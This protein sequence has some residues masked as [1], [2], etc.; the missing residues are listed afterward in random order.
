MRE[1]RDRD[2]RNSR[3]RDFRDRDFRDREP[4]DRDRD[5][6][7]VGERI[8]VEGMQRVRPGIVV[9]AQLKGPD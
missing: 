4:F 5:G 6:L 9:N 1:V 2:F 7:V 8:I 3:D